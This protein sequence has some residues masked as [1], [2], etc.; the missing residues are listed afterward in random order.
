MILDMAMQITGDGSPRT[1]KLFNAHPQEIVDALR[2]KARD[3]ERE[4]GLA[5]KACA[6]GHPMEQ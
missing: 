4:Y 5:N 6:Y 3:L 1:V 2:A